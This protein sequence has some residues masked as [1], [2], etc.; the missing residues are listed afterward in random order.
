MQDPSHGSSIAAR[1]LPRLIACLAAAAGLVA[2]TH[3][4]RVVVSLP[5]P[6]IRFH[7]A[8]PAGPMRMWTSSAIGARA[9]SDCAPLLWQAWPIRASGSVRLTLTT[10]SQ[11]AEHV[12]EWL[13]RPNGTAPGARSNAALLAAIT[14]AVESALLAMSSSVASL[15][16][17]HYVVR[18]APQDCRYRESVEILD[19][20]NAK[21]IL[22]PLTYAASI[23]GPR[24]DATATLIGHL[25]LV[26]AHETAH[27]V[28]LHPFTQERAE[29]MVRDPLSITHGHSMGLTVEFE[30]RLVDH[31]IKEAILPDGPRRRDYMQTLLDAQAEGRE[32]PNINPNRASEEIHLSALKTLAAVLGPQQALDPDDA[33]LRRLFPH[34][35]MALDGRL[36]PGQAGNPTDDDLRRGDEALR[37]IR[38]IVPEPIRFP[39]ALH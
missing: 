5:T 3:R 9:A 7:A 33:A 15:P 27:I 16:P 26:M 6:M 35:V 22:F 14:E 4:E 23:I 10:T 19:P 38:R 37:A 29:R 25:T 2:C 13:E 20:V 30:A 21:E 34:C 32:R 39:G 18:L 8:E 17:V 36:A 24:F 1:G 31:C 11:D 28:Q 12:R